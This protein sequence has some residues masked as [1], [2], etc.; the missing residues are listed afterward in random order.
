[1]E[2]KKSVMPFVFCVLCLLSYL[3]ISLCLLSVPLPALSTMFSPL[4]FP[5]N[6]FL[7]V[8][9]CLS[10]VCPSCLPL[11]LL[12]IISPVL[13]PPLTSLVLLVSSLVSVYLVSA[14]PLLF[15]RPL[16][17]SGVPVVF[18]VPPTEFLVFPVPYGMYIYRL[19]V[20]LGY[21][22]GLKN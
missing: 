16:L 19:A 11:C 21:F 8:S 17:L 10:V 7:S 15:V 13:L 22:E 20:S 6:P 4:Y 12:L 3:L 18:D 1:M 9:L 14:C 5:I 2:K